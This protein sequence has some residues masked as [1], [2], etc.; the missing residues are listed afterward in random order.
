MAWL[1]TPTA[2]G[3]GAVPNSTPY[4]KWYFL[5]GQGPGQALPSQTQLAEIPG[6]GS[7]SVRSQPKSAVWRMRVELT[8]WDE[9]PFQEALKDFSP[10][11][12]LQYL[13]I[14]DDTPVTWVVQ[15]QVEGI[16]V[17]HAN[18]LEVI[19]RVPD[20]VLEQSTGGSDSKLN[21]SGNSFNAVLSVAGTER[22]RPQF[23]I[24]PDLVKTNAV[25]DYS[26]SLRGFIVNRGAPNLLSNIPIQLFDSSGAD[27]SIDTAALIT[28]TTRSNLINNVAGIT[29]IATTIDIDT[30]VGGGLLAPSGM[31]MIAAGGG[32]IEQ[33]Y[34][35]GNSGTQLTGVVRGIG[36]TTATIHNDNTLINNSKA[37]Q[38]GDDCRV[39]LNDKEVDRWL[40]DW[41]TTASRLWINATVPLAQGLVLA[42]AMTASVPA[43]GGSIEFN[44]NAGP[45]IQ[46]L[47]PTGFLII[48]D[49]MIYYAAK[50]GRS[51]T[52]IQRGVWGTTA[53]IHSL[54]V[55]VYSNP[56]RFVVGIGKGKA[57]KQSNPNSA[58]PAI[59]MSGVANGSRNNVWK[60]A[61]S[62]DT[63]SVF[64]DKS[65]PGRSAMFTPGFD[66]DG[67][68]LAPLL[69]LS[70]ARTKL[71][72]KDDTPGGGAPPYNF[73][74]LEMPH[75]IL[76]NDVT[77]ITC[78]WT[79]SAEV[80]N[81]EMFVRDQAGSRKLVDQ[82]Q[83]SAA[84]AGRNL[85][86]VLPSGSPGYGLKLKARYN[87]VT[88][89]K[90]DD[91][92][93]ATMNNTSA[94]VDPVAGQAAIRFT[95][96]KDT[97]IKSLQVRMKLASAG[98]Q[99][100]EWFIRKDSG[101]APGAGSTNLVIWNEPVLV[102]NSTAAA[103]YTIALKRGQLFRPG[104]Y[105]LMLQREAAFGIDTHILGSD[106]GYQVIDA[107]V[108]TG[109][110]WITNGDD[111]PQLYVIG[112]Y[113]ARAQAL[114]Q[115]D[116]PIVTYS[117]GARTATVAS[118]DNLEVKPKYPPYV[119]RTGTF[120]Q[121]LYHCVGSLGSISASIAIDKWMALASTLTIDCKE[122]T[123]VY[124]EGTVPYSVPDVITP[125]DLSDW[126]SLTPDANNTVVYTEANMLQ[127]DLVTSWKARRA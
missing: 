11:L 119:H 99:N 127:T 107:L 89:F 126:F 26:L 38:N 44:V 21:Q 14:V 63:L 125:D 51:V 65:N 111:A 94:P 115:D 13:S 116:Q 46:L 35:T 123:V 8:T 113:D 37:L 58:R 19:F 55:V 68:D 42:T 74:E 82:L 70:E 93:V 88:G 73:A 61:R 90:G 103:T 66:K 86:A 112:D 60:W 33:I 49:E 120:T 62:T 79:P 76:D 100:I 81:L 10:G 36:G 32:S 23:I 92:I 53:A 27:S 47:P 15:C 98:S 114:V 83:Q 50:S 41:N 80:L 84:A 105:W 20:P 28:D 48:E 9:L 52:G 29:A 18:L 3:T 22:C 117:T 97:P 124:T 31:A 16:D 108:Y 122:R 77:A 59:A 91:T 102:V 4:G 121:L 67:N 5:M 30:A 45:G 2:F 106:S 25:D 95:L 1:Y 24:T 69:Q 110:A 40:A 118:F 75:G 39:W 6:K 109:S 7:Q 57:D 71:E 43:N 101:N 12:G 56:L 34:Y 96:E 54:A 87:I 104:T 85:P 64:Y 78:D 72:F 17:I